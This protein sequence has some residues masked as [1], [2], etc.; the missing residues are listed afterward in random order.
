MTYKE[1]IY[2]KY[3]APC[4]SSIIA[5][6]VVVDIAHAQFVPITFGLYCKPV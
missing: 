1:I 4:I 3:D 5:N 6:I 2:L